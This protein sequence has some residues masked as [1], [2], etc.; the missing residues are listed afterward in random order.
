MNFA[1]NMMNS[2]NAVMDVMLL[3]WVSR[4]P[5]ASPA[6]TMKAT[7]FKGGITLCASKN[8]QMVLN[9]RIDSHGIWLF[10]SGNSHGYAGLRPDQGA[11]QTTFRTKGS[12]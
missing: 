10:Q 1:Q 2:V 9:V 6:F 3:D 7:K 8:Q 12:V 11:S 4:N 5:T